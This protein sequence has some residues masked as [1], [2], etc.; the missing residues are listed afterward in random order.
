MSADYKYSILKD[1][2]A[3]KIANKK[4]WKDRI[5]NQ[6]HFLHLLED[7]FGTDISNESFGFYPKR[8]YFA[9]SL[10]ADPKYTK[11]MMPYW[12]KIIK[13]IEKLDWTVYS[14]FDQS[15]PHSKIPDGLDSYQIRDLDHINV[16]KSEA[17]L[18]DLNRPSHGVGQEIEMGLSVPKIGFSQEKV[19]RMV[20]GMPGILVLN[21][22]DEKELISLLKKIFQRTSYKKEPFYIEKCSEHSTKSIFK[23]EICLN[24]EFDSYI[25]KV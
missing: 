18:M 1:I 9:T 21:Y 23:G 2:L 19:S 7:V 22:K 13:A 11:S 20:K 14:P 16:L 5:R 10:T 15:N 8:I 12:H 6:T 4:V 25:H 17:A 3:V 24:C